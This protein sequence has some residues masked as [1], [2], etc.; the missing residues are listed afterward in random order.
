[1]VN[2]KS[3][4]NVLCWGRGGVLNAER[5][6]NYEAIA[7][8]CACDAPDHAVLVEFARILRATYP[9]V[10]FVRR[11]NPKQLGADLKQ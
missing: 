2:D 1:M 4:T 6:K 8:C 11:F 10:V 3:S 5:G 9:S 7:V